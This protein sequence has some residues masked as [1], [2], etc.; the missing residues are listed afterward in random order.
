MLS[1]PN[2]QKPFINC[3]TAFELPSIKPGNIPPRPSLRTS[4]RRLIFDCL[5]SPTRAAAN[6]TKR[7]LGTSMRKGAPPYS[8]RAASSADINLPEQSRKFNLA[9][10]E[11]HKTL[12]KDQHCSSPPG[13][14][15]AKKRNNKRSSDRIPGHFSAWLALRARS[16]GRPG[17]L[18]CVKSKAPRGTMGRASAGFI[19]FLG[20]PASARLA[21]EQ[22]F[23]R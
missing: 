16:P 22:I 10:Q 9:R 12:A 15:S 5:Q 2:N 8:S 19:F 20:P 14:A 7:P 3:A 13:G 6:P 11:R 17:I 21:R 23:G 1:N 4:S 18:R